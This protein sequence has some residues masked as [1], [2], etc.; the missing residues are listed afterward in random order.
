[1][2]KEL[3]RKLRQPGATREDTI[4]LRKCLRAISDLRKAEKER[5]RLKTA[6]HQESLYFKDKWEFARNAVKGTLDKT[7]QAPTFT[8]H[9]ADDYF[10]STYSSPREI[11]LEQLQWFPSLPVT[12][13]HSDFEPFNMDPI[14][15]KD[16]LAALKRSNKN[17]AP[18]PDGITYGIL[19][20][21]TAAHKPLATLF[22]KILESG[23]PPSCWSES[24]IKLIHKAGDTR[25]PK[26]FGRSHLEVVWGNFLI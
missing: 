25:D 15:P 13:E 26:T 9:T 24:V 12:P 19:L 6:K 20:K 5:D 16:V 3:N 22:S 8:K 11:D 2:K 23:A 18:G 7:E 14:R 10:K 4:A 17:S 1:M 21:L